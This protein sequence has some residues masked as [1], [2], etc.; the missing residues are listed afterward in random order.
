MPNTVEELFKKSNELLE[1]NVR[2]PAIF[3]KLAERGYVPA[4]EEEAQELM[5][6]A[7]AISAGVASGEVA[8]IPARELE[9]DGSLSKHA[10]E[11]ADQDF[12]RFAP[13]VE[14]NI[15]EVDKTIKQAAAVVAMVNIGQ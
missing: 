3:Q 12:L 8:T 13:E 9:T 11:A 10:S 7:E 6:H 4:T 15:N 2:I 14:V 1:N 5:K